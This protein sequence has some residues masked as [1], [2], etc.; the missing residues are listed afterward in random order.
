MRFSDFFI[1]AHAIKISN[2]Y[3]I[4]LILLALGL[5]SKNASIFLQLTLIVIT[6]ILITIS[7]IHAIC[8]IAL[9]T[10]VNHKGFSRKKYNELLSQKEK[11]ESEKR[12]QERLKFQQEKIKSDPVSNL[13][14]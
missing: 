7:I 5:N 6:N 11:E 1:R 8:R 3:G 9:N 2:I 13:K 12:I 10:N 4:S 14:K